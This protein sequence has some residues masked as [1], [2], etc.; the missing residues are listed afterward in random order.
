MKLTFVIKSSNGNCSWLS[1]KGCSQPVGLL[2]APCL[3]Q[4][5]DHDLFKSHSG[6]FGGYFYLCSSA[7]VGA[8]KYT[9]LCRLPSCLA[10][11]SKGQ[12]RAN[13]GF[14]LLEPFLVDVVITVSGLR[15]LIFSSSMSQIHSQ[16]MVSSPLQGFWSSWVQVHPYLSKRNAADSDGK[17]HEC[18][19]LSQ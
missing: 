18:R 1:W 15:N 17:L 19:S 8:A 13:P 14:L 11:W 6:A 10:K 5:S 9:P 4:T 7:D 12:V 2:P 3:C 16:W